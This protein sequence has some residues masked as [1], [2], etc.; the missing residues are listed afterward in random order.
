M[1]KA[2]LEHDMDSAQRIR[3]L[4]VDDSAVFR[5]TM[6]S[7]LAFHSIEVVGEASDGHEAVE[8]VKQLQPTVVLM[9]IYLNQTMDGIATTRIITQHYPQVA[10]LGLSLDT[11]P[12]VVSA[13]EQ[14]GA[15]QVLSKDQR[16]Q[17][18]YEAI[19]RAASRMD[20]G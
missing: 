3:V 2:A 20:N 8:L 16:G 12:Y 11:R 15:L 17:E 1:H 6:R 4:L 18:V 10:I 7:I 14:A 9:D 13:M 5:R 19:Q